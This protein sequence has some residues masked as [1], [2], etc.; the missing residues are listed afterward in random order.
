LTGWN[1]I[2]ARAEQLGLT[3]TDEQLKAATAHI[4]TLADA[5]P[6]SLADVDGV[7]RRWVEDGK[8]HSGE[9]AADRASLEEEPGD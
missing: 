3:M 2:K 8:T 1:A 7:L 9:E 5:K 6:L 4:K